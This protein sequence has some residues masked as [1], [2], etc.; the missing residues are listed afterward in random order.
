MVY[1]YNG[2]KIYYKF[3]HGRSRQPILLL[4]GWGCDGSIFSSLIDTFRDRS[5]LVID[6]PPFGKSEPNIKNWNIYTYANMVMSLCDDLCIDKCHILAHSFGGRVALILMAVRCSFVQSCILTGCAG[7]KPRHGPSYHYRIYKYK[8]L[9]KL[10][11]DTS[12]MGSSDYLALSPD[13]RKVFSSIVQEHLDDY[14]K[15]INTKTLII[16]GENDNQTP[17]YMAKKLN[18]YIKGSTLIILKKA[19]HFTFLDKPLEFCM[20]VQQFWEREL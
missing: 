12:N 20:A 8:L 19:G 1:N 13:M 10:G 2:S 4:H 9:K 18:K 7:I 6:F 11:R 3:Y 17:L 5:F 16:W 15:K 14:C